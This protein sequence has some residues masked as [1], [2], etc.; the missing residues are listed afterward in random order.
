MK[1]PSCGHLNDGAYKFCLGCGGLLS[2][3]PAPEP[4]G[5]GG[6][7]T[8]QGA[9]CGHC[10]GGRTIQGGVGPQMGVRVATSAGRYEDVPISTGWVCLDCGHVGMFLPENAR[11]YLASVTGR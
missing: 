1:C 11:Q 4:G 10:G 5:S 7:S 9:R 8:G 2:R 3:Q 6:G